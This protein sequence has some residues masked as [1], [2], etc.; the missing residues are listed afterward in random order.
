MVVVVMIVYVAVAVVVA[1]T[2]A[3]W[4]HQTEGAQRQK[5]IATSTRH[6]RLHSY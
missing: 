5:H 3:Q 6:R 2:A 1:M 4:K